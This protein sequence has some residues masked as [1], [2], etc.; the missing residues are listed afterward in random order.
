MNRSD[1]NNKSIWKTKHHL[2]IKPKNWLHRLYHQNSVINEEN[3]KNLGLP[4]ETRGKRRYLRLKGK[5][6]KTDPVKYI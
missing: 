3:E 1:I 4:G 5:L 6:R 2:A